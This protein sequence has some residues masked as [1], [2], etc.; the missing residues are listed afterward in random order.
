MQEFRPIAIT[1]HFYQLGT[2]FFPVYLSL[3]ED[4]MLIEGGTGA[5]TDIIVHQIQELGIDPRRIKYIALTHTHADHVGAIPRLKALWPHLQLVAGDKAPKLLGNEK[6]I[7]Q[8][9]GM[10][11]AIAG[12]M[13]EKG[14][15]PAVPETLAEYLFPVDRIVVEGDVIDLGTG[16]AGP[17]IRPP[18][19]PPVTSPG[20]RKRKRSSPSGTP[21]DI[22][23]RR[24]TPSGPITTFPWWSTAKAFENSETFPQNTWPS[25]TT[26]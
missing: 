20:G 19:I 7:K 25:A 3:G 5:T 23:P 22:I 14:E 2:P 17:S 13:K 4:A 10:D 8:F 26:G 9:V 15:I 1:P 18:G 6:V 11:G 24:K 16:C 21:S 12:I